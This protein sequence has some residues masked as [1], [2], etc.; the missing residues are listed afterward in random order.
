MRCASQR[1]SSVASLVLPVVF[2]TQRVALG[3]RRV[4]QGW[5]LAVHA[6]CQ[7]AT[8][9]CGV[10]GATFG[11]W[12]TACDP[13][14]PASGAGLGYCSACTRCASEWRGCVA[15]LV[16]PAVC[17]TQRV[18]SDSACPRGCQTQLHLTTSLS[19]G[20]GYCFAT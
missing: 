12:D 19:T 8:R 14:G 6:L 16:P 2:W 15:S 7:S 5:G 9:L 3:G 4:L 13:G 1:R 17:W 20:G 11:V 18:G 10:S